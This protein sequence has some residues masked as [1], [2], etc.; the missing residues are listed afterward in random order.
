MKNAIVSSSRTTSKLMTVKTKKHLDEKFKLCHAKTGCLD[1]IRC[2][3]AGC[4]AC[5]NPAYPECK[6]SCPL[7]DD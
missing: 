7:F 6:T 1:S 3:E 5:G 2:I 4:R